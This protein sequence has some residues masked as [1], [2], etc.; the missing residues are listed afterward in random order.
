MSRGKQHFTPAEKK[1]ICGQIYD[2]KTALENKSI[3]G[4]TAKAIE[5]VADEK[6]V[7]EITIRGIYYGTNY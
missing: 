1:S 2:I 5:Q 6:E 3:R 4:A 7:K